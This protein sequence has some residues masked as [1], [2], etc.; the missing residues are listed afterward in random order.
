[1]ELVAAKEKIQQLE[2]KLLDIKTVANMKIED[3]LAGENQ[4]SI[5]AKHE[6]AESLGGF[7]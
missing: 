1:M 4:E 5:L 7:C 6:I 3:F 2:L